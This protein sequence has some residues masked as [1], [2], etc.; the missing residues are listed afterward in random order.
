M[1]AQDSGRSKGVPTNA[2]RKAI[3]MRR[4]VADCQGKQRWACSGPA[5]SGG[6]LLLTSARSAYQAL[7]I[8]SVVADVQASAVARARD[9]C[10][11]HWCKQGGDAAAHIKIDAG[12]QQDCLL[13]GA[14]RSIK[15]PPGG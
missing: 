14:V 7:C 4:L 10:S 12:A 3:C 6:H 11:D 5:R 2:V 1:T 13:Q 8:C 15:R 9:A